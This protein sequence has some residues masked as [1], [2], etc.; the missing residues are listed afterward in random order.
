MKILMATMGLDIGGAET[1]IVE[2]AKELKRQGNDVAIAS[3]G[4]VYVPEV[5][6][7]GIRHYEVPMNRRSIPLMLKSLRLMRGIIREEKPDVV[8]AHA[9]IP[10]FLCGILK[11]T[12][13]FPFVTTAHW[14]FDTG[15]ALRFLT[16]WGDKTVSVSDDISEYLTE[17]YGI[18]KKDIFVTI[19]GIDT[20]KFSP[21]ISGEK[22]R[23]EFGID[24]DVPFISHVSRMDESRALAARFLIDAAPVIESRHPG[25]VILIAGGGD[26]FDELCRLSEE[27]NL[28]IGRRCVIMAGPRTDINEIV[29]AGDIFVGVSRAALEA[30]SEAKP[31]VIAGNEGYMGIFTPEK[32]EAG[33]EGNFCCRGCGEIEA[34]SF[35]DDVSDLLSLPDD[36]RQKLGEYG[37]RVVMEHYSVSKM[38]RDTMAAYSAAKPSKHVVMSGYYGFGNAGDEAILESVHNSIKRICPDALVTVLS[39]DPAGTE[40]AYGCAAVPRFNSLAI[41]RTIKNCD[42][43]VSGGGSLLQDTTST[44]SLLYYLLIIRMA[45]RMGKKVILYA[46]GIGPVSKPGNRRRVKKAVECADAVTLRDPDSLRELKDMGVTR[47]DIQVTADPVF[48]LGEPEDSRTDE[49]L[50]AAGVPDGPFITVSVRLWSNSE[51][52]T[53]QFALICDSLSRRYRENIVFVAMQPA[54]DEAVSRQIA[55]KMES[56]AYVVSGEYSA[57]ELMGVIG[58]SDLI[59][60]M[61]LHSIIFAARMATPAVGFVY[62]PKVEAY[63]D[64]LS[65]PSAGSAEKLDVKRAVDAASEILEHREDV[66]G[67]LRE[68]RDEVMLMAKRNDDV[69]KKFL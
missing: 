29:A 44:R 48:L 55:D 18:P 39:K 54:R 12:M 56:K 59:L 36:E 51:E 61:R 5:E 53:K 19:N 60:S 11:K 43:L 13:H 9:R 50:L 40:A 69:L 33:I 24:R 52:F 65:L 26:V 45:E 25:T 7:A 6:A 31:S 37:R 4:G 16:N 62:D 30:M 49:I 21:E 27:V 47:E 15:G 63:L 58:R 2:L 23:S 46:N 14:V 66:A 8:H 38:A 42:V 17:N 32:L 64:M 35:T 3:N 68:K 1:H 57:K 28:K 41:L 20:D 34:R 22:V 67:K 10:A